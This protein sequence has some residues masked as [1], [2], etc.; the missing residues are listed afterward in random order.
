MQ[1]QEISE[2]LKSCYYHYYYHG[3]IKKNYYYHGTGISIRTLKRRVRHSSLRR[4]QIPF[5][6]NIVRGIIEREMGPG[7]IK[8]YKSIHHTLK[9]SYGAHVPKDNLMQILKK[10]N[11]NETEERKWKKLRR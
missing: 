3:V 4:K 9:Q 8:G 11:L 2:L 6:K 7:P 5:N 10:I 1:S